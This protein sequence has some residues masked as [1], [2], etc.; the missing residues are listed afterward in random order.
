M[1]SNSKVKGVD[2]AKR[3]TKKA[4]TNGQARVDGL[5]FDQEFLDRENIRF[6][7]IQ[8]P[9]YV[10]DDQ[11]QTRVPDKLDA[12]T[13][14]LLSAEQ[15]D[16]ANRTHRAISKMAMVDETM[17]VKDREYQRYMTTRSESSRYVFT[18]LHRAAE[19]EMQ[20]M[21]AAREAKS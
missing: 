10:G 21:R 5:P 17:P 2:V 4:E 13:L 15:R 12:L 16:G 19:L 14:K 20:K 3:R 18:L 11:L 8:V 9:M 6:I 1:V 7:T